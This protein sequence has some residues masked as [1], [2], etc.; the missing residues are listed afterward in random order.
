MYVASISCSEDA[1]DLSNWNLSTDTYTFLYN[2]NLWQQGGKAYSCFLHLRVQRHSAACRSRIA[3][4]AEVT[5]P[6]LLKMVNLGDQLLLNWVTLKSATQEPQQLEL[7]VD[8]YTTSKPGNAR[9]FST[10]TCSVAR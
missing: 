7:K 2:P 10:C 5:A 6:V 1:V 4:D 3:C 8:H 9:R